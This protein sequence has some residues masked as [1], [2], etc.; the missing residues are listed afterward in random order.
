MLFAYLEH[1][2][3]IYAPFKPVEMTLLKDTYVHPH[4]GQVIH[5]MRL[6]R[7]K[8]KQAVAQDLHWSTG[9][10]R[11]VEA[12]PDGTNRMDRDKALIPYLQIPPILLGLDEDPFLPDTPGKDRQTA[13]A[14][15]N[16]L[17]QGPTTDDSMNEMERILTTYRATRDPKFV[18]LNAKELEGY[19]QALHE[20]QKL[21]FSS[22]PENLSDL[23][24]HAF[25]QDQSSLQRLYERRERE[26]ARQ[27]FLLIEHWLEHTSEALKHATGL[28]AAQ[29]FYVRYFLYT[30]VTADYLFSCE[31]SAQLDPTQKLVYTV[32][33][34]EC[35]RH[36]G[37]VMRLA[38]ALEERVKIYLKEQEFEQVVADV[39]E[40][41]FCI[42]LLCTVLERT[43]VASEHLRCIEHCIGETEGD[44]KIEL[45]ALRTKVQHIIMRTGPTKPT[46]TEEQ[47]SCPTF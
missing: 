21:L 42:D 33:R 41:V 47:A 34:V 17:L 18:S 14:Q 22:F 10:I 26:R 2:W 32:E 4:F 20:C 16:A 3:D 36:L 44:V 12:S 25:A 9:Y 40:L 1:W 38:D 28:R 8:S 39:T 31:A 45:R 29:L 30:L 11:K 37:N 13:L 27:G 6:L 35:A 7:H 46:P 24:K 43:E 19:N 23:R 15:V 5:Y